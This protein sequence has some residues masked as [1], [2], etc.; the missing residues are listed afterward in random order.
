MPRLNPPDNS[1]VGE[2]K[3]GA[4]R[5]NTSQEEDTAA[6]ELVIEEP[7]LAKTGNGTPSTRVQ[8]PSFCLLRIITQEAVNFVTT[9]IW[10]EPTNVFLPRYF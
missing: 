5:P 7:I 2:A 8:I 10:N 1:P 9:G 4:E 6:E 3:R